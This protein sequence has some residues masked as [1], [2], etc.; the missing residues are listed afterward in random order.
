MSWDELVYRVTML[1]VILGLVWL[2]FAPMPNGA[3]LVQFVHQA[4]IA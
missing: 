1:A 4:L 2:V 3:P